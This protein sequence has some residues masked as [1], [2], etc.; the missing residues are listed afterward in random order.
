MSLNRIRA[1]PCWQG[2]ITA[3]PLTGGLSNESWKVTDATGDHVVR[4]GN[5]YP[6]HHVDRVR[7]V[8]TSR[9]AHAAGFAPE[10]EHA[11]PGI[12][13]STFLDART[14]GA[15]TCEPTQKASPP[16]CTAFT[17]PCRPISPARAS[18]S[19]RST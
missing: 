13:V 19:G 5:D 9:A 7:E 10:V 16:C 8:M 17:T 15:T 12:M 6:F 14:W 1:L 4:F 18:Y 11:E 2:E 3:E